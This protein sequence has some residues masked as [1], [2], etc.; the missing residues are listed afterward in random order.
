MNHRIAVLEATARD[1]DK[2]KIDIGELM[3]RKLN[4]W[5]TENH[6]TIVQEIHQNTISTPGYASLIITLR[7]SL[8]TK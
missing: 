6:G 4:Q 1:A 5:Y 2:E 7:Y 8:P 3:Q